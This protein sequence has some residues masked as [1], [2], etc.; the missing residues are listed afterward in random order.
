MYHVRDSYAY[1]PI[2]WVLELG[3][4]KRGRVLKAL[5]DSGRSFHQQ[6][7]EG[8]IETA[9]Q[10]NASVVVSSVVV[11]EKK[12]GRPIPLNTVSL[13]KACSKAL[14]IGPHAAMQA[15]ERLY[16]SGYL[17]YPRTESTAYPKSF[18]IQGTLQQQSSDARWGAY[19]REFLTQGFNK[20]RGG[21]DMGDHPPITPCRA[22]NPQELSGDMG[23]VY[24]LV[25]R[26]FIA[27]VS[28][29]AVWKSTKIGFEIEAL[30]DKGKFSLS[31]KELVSPGFLAVLLHK[32][33]GDKQEGDDDEEEEERQIPEFVKG[34][35]IPLLKSNSSSASSKVNVATSAPVWASLDIKEKKT[36]PPTYL[37]ESE[38]IGLMEK[39]GIG[40][41]ASIPTH[42]QNI[43]NRNYVRLET[44]RRLVPNKLGLVLVQG[45]HQIDSSLVL[46]KVRS[47]IE[48]Q[49][50]R[51]AKGEAEKDDVV[52]RAIEIFEEKFGYFVKHIDRMDVLF[53]SSFSKLEDVGK[54]FTRC[55]HTRYVQIFMMSFWSIEKCG[56]WF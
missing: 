41:D 52:R 4:L 44:G 19:V 9:L 15:A 22:A 30:G 12:Q 45:Y 34:E 32:E 53:S 24:E 31:G 6:K 26:H 13:L 42:I 35:S 51:I 10:E 28:H 40:T 37:T 38:L 16:L 55:G 27:S 8:L 11:K 50:N 5:W 49:C 39:H 48:G 46:P 1:A 54:A 56:S 18:D 3:I 20:S 25:V 47:D 23:R 17:S 29:D 43:Q 14:G 2:D 21:V 33:Y 36:T 7:V